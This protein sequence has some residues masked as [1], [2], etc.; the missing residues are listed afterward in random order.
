MN[1]IIG[2]V[3][4]KELTVIDCD[5]EEEIMVLPSLLK[6]QDAEGSVFELKDFNFEKFTQCFSKKP[7][8]SIVTKLDIPDNFLKKGNLME[9]I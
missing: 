9:L 8:P 2:S 5:F 1:K 3:K 6:I 7:K 4:L